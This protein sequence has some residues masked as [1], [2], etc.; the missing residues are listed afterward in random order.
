LNIQDISNRFL[1]ISS[2]YQFEK[3]KTN[4]SFVQKDQLPK[5]LSVNKSNYFDPGLLKI[6]NCLSTSNSWHFQRNSKN[7]LHN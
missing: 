6:A 7:I 5:I 2:T 3:S 1:C 4:K